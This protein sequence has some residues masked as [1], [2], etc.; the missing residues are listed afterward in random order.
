VA[1]NRKRFVCLEAG[2]DRSIEAES[3]EQLVAAVQAHMADA[4]NSFELEDFIL[5]AATE[6]SEGVSEEVSEEG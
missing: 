2:C 6:V 5:A 3:D 4:H 1:G